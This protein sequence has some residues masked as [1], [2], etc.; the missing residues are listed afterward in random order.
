MMKRIKMKKNYIVAVL[1]SSMVLIGHAF[2]APAQEDPYKDILFLIIDGEYESAVK[3]AE[4]ITS[5]DKTRR[6]P[7]PYIYA[8]MAYFEM[9]KKEEFQEDYPRAF[10]DAITAAYK[11]RRYDRENEHFPKHA[12][13]INELKAEIMREAIYLF[14]SEQWRKSTT[15]AKYVTRIDP[16]DVSAL[17]LTGISE[18]NARNL[19]QAKTTFETAEEALKEFSDSD[20]AFENRMSYLF[21]VLEY[22]KLME[23]DGNKAQAQP[24][25]DA[26]ASVYEDDAEFQNFYE[27]Y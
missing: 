15:Y 27:S 21:A 10:R 22:A 25:L 19:H 7:V 8:S 14:Q 3:Q 5:R 16:N 17:L 11:A 13:Y 1:F 26:I 23:K 18:V 2:S 9:S 20:I 24:Y 12:N 6:E 4:R